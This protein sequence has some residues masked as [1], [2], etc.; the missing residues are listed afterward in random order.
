MQTTAADIQAGWKYFRAWKKRFWLSTRSGTRGSVYR[1]NDVV[2]LIDHDGLAA[3]EFD[4]DEREIFDIADACDQKVKFM[5]AYLIQMQLE[6]HHFERDVRRLLKSQSRLCAPKCFGFWFWQSNM[7]DFGT[8]GSPYFQGDSISLFCE[9][10]DG[11]DF[12]DVYSLMP[13]D[14]LR[15]RHPGRDWTEK[16]AKAFV[17]HLVWD[18]AFDGIEANCEFDVHWSHL[19]VYVS[20]DED[21]VPNRNLRVSSHKLTDGLERSPNRATKASGRRRSLRGNQTS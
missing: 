5:H 10:L 19:N 16:E 14:R 12:A 1:P 9:E 13:Y 6:A 21:R 3:N 8:G 15:V 7:N 2:Y 20:S 11:V 17:A 4:S 18:L